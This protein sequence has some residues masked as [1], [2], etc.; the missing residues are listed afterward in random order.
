[1]VVE[2][3][4]KKR[5]ILIVDDEPGTLDAVAAVLEDAEYRVEKASNGK[6]A[7]DK[8]AGTTDFPIDAMIV[9]Y[10]MPV[11]DGAETVRTLRADEAN[12]DAGRLA[13]AFMSGVPESMIFRRVKDYDAFLR[14]PFGLDELLTCVKKLVK[15]SKPTVVVKKKKPRRG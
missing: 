6:E 12:E 15:M 14:K 2:K 3:L 10:L 7:L 8:I 1:M 13:V 5:T 9:D 4:K 11:L